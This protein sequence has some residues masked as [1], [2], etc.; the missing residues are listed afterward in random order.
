MHRIKN[1][2]RKVATLALFSVAIIICSDMWWR[3]L[4]ELFDGG[5]ELLN[6]LYNISMGYFVSYIFYILVV[7]L[8]EYKNKQ[9]IKTI[10]TPIV[11]RI[12]ETNAKVLSVEQTL[13]VDGQFVN[14]N[15]IIPNETGFEPEGTT[16]CKFLLCNLEHIEHNLVVLEKFH[17]HLEPEFIEICEQVRSTELTISIKCID[18]L[19]D[20]KKQYN[21]KR[22]QDMYRNYQAKINRIVVP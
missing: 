15:A 3:D 8:P 4:P 7:Y 10:T 5:A 6:S 16:W 1:V 21:Y 9:H 11:K 19:N 2:D 18:V 17:P 20:P 12:I 14:L 13:S 22:L